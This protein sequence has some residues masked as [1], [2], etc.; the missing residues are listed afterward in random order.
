MLIKAKTELE[1]TAWNIAVLEESTAV[2]VDWVLQE[3]QCWRDHQQQQ[4]ESSDLSLFQ[5][6][7]IETTGDVSQLAIGLEQMQIG[8]GEPVSRP[9]YQEPS[10]AKL[11]SVPFMPLQRSGF[12]NNVFKS[13]QNFFKQIFKAPEKPGKYL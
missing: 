3:E 4:H 10:A 11:A 8:S 9:R 1:E 6:T 12:L 7:T 13:V 2:E 5:N